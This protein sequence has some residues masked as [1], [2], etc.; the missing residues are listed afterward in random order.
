MNLSEKNISPQLTGI[1]HKTEYKQENNNK[2]GFWNIY[3]G[4]SKK[5]EKWIL[6]LN[7]NNL[8]SLSFYGIEENIFC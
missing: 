7:N 2:S 5:D 4:K 8:L 6:F 3:F 1:I